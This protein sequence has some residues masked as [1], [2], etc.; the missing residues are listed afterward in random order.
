M[1]KEDTLVKIKPIN[2]SSLVDKVEHRL[3]EYFE[4][5]NL[6]PGDALPKE[7]DLARGLG[8]SRT[9]V[10]EALTRLRTLGFVDSKKNRGM[11]LTRPDVLSSFE[12][13]LNPKIMSLSTLQDVFEWRMVLEIGLAD[14]IFSRKS[15]ADLEALEEIVD[16]AE[17]E[18]GVVAGFNAQHE[19]EF[20]G[21]L[22]EMSGNNTL[23]RFQSMLFPVFQYV[24]DNGLFIKDYPYPK[25]YATHRKLLE[26]IKHGTASDFAVAMQNHLRPSMERILGIDQTIDIAS[27]HIE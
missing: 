6:K 11:V 16:R 2:T 1:K 7:L 20:H 23:R 21:K 12:K 8:V 10:R 22:Y 13:V 25:G 14:L 4:Q 24:I 18:E 3:W 26:V 15:Q 27:G 19:M 17:M 9:V 5:N